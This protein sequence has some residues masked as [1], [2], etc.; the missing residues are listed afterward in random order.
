MSKCLITGCGGFI[1]SYLAD[2]LIQKRF[3][4]YGLVRKGAKK[5]YPITGG[6]LVW[7][8]DV[9]HNKALDALVA[10]IRPDYVFHMAA[11]SNI[12]LS[13]QNPEET[14]KVNVLGTLYLL[15]A[16]R[17]AGIYPLV[18]VLCS[19]AEY[20]GSTQENVTI[21]ETDELRSSS[22]YGVSKVAAD[23][24]AHLYWQVY[25]VKVI[26][27]RPFYI[28]GPG[29]TSDVVSNFACGIAEIEAGR[30]NIL[31][32]GNLEAVR[33]I[34]DIRDCVRA[35]GLLMRAGTPGEA[36]NVSSGKGYS[37]GEILQKFIMLS[38]Q[39]IPVRRSSKKLRPLD[40]HFLIGNNSKLSALGWKPEIPLEQT[41]ADILDFWRKRAN[42][43]K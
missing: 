20:A 26:R 34:V 29:K 33:D 12:P 19:S 38:P 7:E 21:K 4:V 41:L 36:Y 6:V 3:T 14:L 35:M 11:Q 24:L 23:L 42:A 22:P 2:Y 8:S 27:L 13:W 17:K 32:V 15:E 18:Q 25:K 31:E 40:E 1:G 37:I 28:V 5:Q 16:I 39:R 43:F 9:L 10:E 30:R